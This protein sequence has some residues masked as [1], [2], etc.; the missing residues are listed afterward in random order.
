[1]ASERRKFITEDT[2]INIDEEVF[3]EKATEFI[4]ESFVDYVN[5]LHGSQVLEIKL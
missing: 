3:K 2:K 5:E 1:M 4:V